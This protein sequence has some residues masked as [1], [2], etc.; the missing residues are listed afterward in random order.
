MRRKLAQV[1]NVRNLLAA[2]DSLKERD[3]GVPGMGLLY[4]F[5]GAGKS[6][7]IDWLIVQRR[8]VCVRA[9]ATWTPYA[10]LA[11]IMQELGASPMGRSAAMARYI[12][13]EL[14]RTDRPLFVDEADYLLH[15]TRMLETLRDLHDASDVPVMLIGME[16]LDRKLAHRQQLCRRISQWVEFRP[17]SPED[18]RILA[19][20]VCEVA[21]ADDLLERL[22]TQAKG[23]IGL[24]VVGLSRVEAVARANRLIG[25]G[26]EQW[27]NEPF[28]LARG[29]S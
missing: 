25:I 6:T 23:S 2:Y 9:F 12:A 8:G 14:R 13:D 15:D 17:A 5:T 19:S 21:V 4:G 26:L 7:A 29:S 10:M 16:G 11:E 27:G 3:P 1:T 22:H 28:F 24:M 18:A 20:T